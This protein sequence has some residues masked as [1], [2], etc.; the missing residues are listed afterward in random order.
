MSIKELLKFGMEHR[1]LDLINQFLCTYLYPRRFVRVLCVPL[2]VLYHRYEE[3]MH[4]GSCFIHMY[5]CRYHIFLPVPFGKKQIHQL[6][7]PFG[8][9][10][11]VLH[12]PKFRYSILGDRTV[13]MFGCLLF[14]N[15][16][17][18]IIKYRY[19]SRKC[20]APS[21]VHIHISSVKALDIRVRKSRFK[22]FPLFPAVGTHVVI[23]MRSCRIDTLVPKSDIVAV[24]VFFS[25]AVGE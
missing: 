18:K 15:D 22:A 11:G 20:N 12:F 24:F 3:E 1:H 5:I 2:F 25:F 16:V 4:M 10:A 19:M 17:P 21:T 7:E 23:K 13:L 9:F 14:I 6:K 8:L